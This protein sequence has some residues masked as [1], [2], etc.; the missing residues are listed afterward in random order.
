MIIIV[1]KKGA[2]RNFQYFISILLLVPCV[3]AFDCVSIYVHLLHEFHRHPF[4]N[5]TVNII[6]NRCTP[7][8]TKYSHHD[9]ACRIYHWIQ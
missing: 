7:S 1:H 2:L 8:I 5:N 4:A 9:L 3:M 6:C